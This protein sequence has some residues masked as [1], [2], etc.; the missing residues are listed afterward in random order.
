MYLFL[1]NVGCLIC[2]TTKGCENT[3]FKEERLEIKNELNIRSK[4]LLL[5]DFPDEELIN[6]FLVRKDNISKLDLR[7]K[8]PDLLK[9]VVSLVLYSKTPFNT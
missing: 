8:Q 3:K 9:F 2:K 5:P 1:F 4:A 6:E 7:W